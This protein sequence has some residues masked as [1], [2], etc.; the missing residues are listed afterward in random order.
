MFPSKNPRL[1]ILALVANFI[2]VPA[3]AYGFP[4]IIPGS[5]DCQRIQPK[6]NGSKSKQRMEPETFISHVPESTHENF[7]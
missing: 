1:V 7:S 3:F 5:H 4:A 6:A 2:L